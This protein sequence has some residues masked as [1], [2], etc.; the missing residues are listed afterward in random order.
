M[1]P[2]LTVNN[3]RDDQQQ[4]SSQQLHKFPIQASSIPAGKCVFVQMSTLLPELC[5]AAT[6]GAV[7]AT[8]V[9]ITPYPNFS[10]R[11][12][13]SKNTSKKRQNCSTIQLGAETSY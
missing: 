8:C 9:T 10:Q 12:T 4:N 13:F 11:L 1:H 6:P 5:R 2:N 3:S 7:A